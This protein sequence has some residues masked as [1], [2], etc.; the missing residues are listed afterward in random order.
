MFNKFTRACP[1]IKKIVNKKN[2][3]IAVPPYLDCGPIVSHMTKQKELA[4]FKSIMFFLLIDNLLLFLEIIEKIKIKITITKIT[5]ILL[6]SAS[7]GMC[8]K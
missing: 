6:K 1:L 8:F 4:K 2:D 7:K 3:K 5:S